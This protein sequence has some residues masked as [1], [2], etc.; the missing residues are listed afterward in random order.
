MNKNDTAIPAVA[1]AMDNLRLAIGRTLGALRE[2][3]LE[4]LPKENREAIQYLIDHADD[5]VTVKEFDHE[6][7]YGR[8]Y[9]ATRG[10]FAL[11]SNKQ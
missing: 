6:G 8:T 5:T 9:R 1:A 3:D 11:H 2:L 7:M 10:I 4:A